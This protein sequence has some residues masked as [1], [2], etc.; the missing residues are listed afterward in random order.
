MSSQSDDTRPAALKD[1]SESWGL[2]SDERGWNECTINVGDDDDDD[3][4]FMTRQLTEESLDRS[5]F[6]LDQC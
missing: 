6:M 2:T 4:G 1:K 5:T 3:S